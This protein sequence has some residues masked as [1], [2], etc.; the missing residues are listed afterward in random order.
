MSVSPPACRRKKPAAP[1]SPTAAASSRSSRPSA[2]AAPEPP[3]KPSPRIFATLSVSCARSPAFAALAIL[4]LAIGIGANTAI[5]SFVNS[6][7]LRPLPYPN[8]DR[9][10][11]LYSGLG[12]SNRA[13]FSSFELYQIRQRTQ[14]FDQVAGIWVTNGPL[15]GE[16]D[17]EQV[18]VADTTSNFLPLLIPRPAMGRFFGPEDD[19]P[20]APNVIILSHAVWVRRF[21]SD[22]AIIG[23]LVRF[24]RRKATVVGVLPASFRLIFPDDA[25][26]PPNPDVYESI[27]VGAWDPQGP[28][29]LHVIGRLRNHS[30]PATRTI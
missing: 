6:V 23:K 15:P 16:G 11:I 27:P 20:D 3:S 4:T 19:L 17:A 2:I 22:P 18:K 5:F 1:P 12:Y 28:A 21:G 10:T 29:F 14:Q 24:G 26:V 13:P 9:L 7:L 8:A 30:T 25:S